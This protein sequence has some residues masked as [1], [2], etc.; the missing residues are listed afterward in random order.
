ME[1][2]LKDNVLKGFFDKD[3]PKATTSDAK[4]LDEWKKCVVK[5]TQIITEEFGDHIV[6]SLHGK[7]NP[8]AMWKALIDVYQNFSN[9]RKLAVKDKIRKIKMEKGE[10]IPKYLIKFIESGDEVGIVAITT[11]GDDT[12]S[13]P[14][15][16]L[17]N[18]WQHYQDF[19]NG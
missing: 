17:P 12:M 4:N 3:I 16:G 18:S 15:L 13:L 8:Y 14:L 2:V 10:I 11:T 1:F 5:V 7:G 6:S 9:E 19:I